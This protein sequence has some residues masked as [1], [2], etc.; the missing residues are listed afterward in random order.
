[1]A[2]PPEQASKLRAFNASLLD[3]DPEMADAESATTE[4]FEV[5]LPPEQTI[6]RESIVMRRRRPVLAIQKCAAV[7]EFEDAQDVP[8]WKS[9]LEGAA[10]A[11]G[12]VIPSVGRI[13]LAGHPDF[14]WVGTGWLVHP[15]YFV[16]NRHVAEVFARGK[17]D[18]FVMQSG[19]D[20]DIVASI[21]LLQEIGR[22]DTH[23]FKVKGISYIESRPGLD[24]AFFEVEQIAG[25]VAKPIILSASAPT[26]NPRV[27]TIGYP[28]FDSRIPEPDLMRRIYGDVFDKKRLAPGAIT[29]VDQDRVLHNCTTLGGNSGSVVVDL[30]SGDALG[31]HF[32]G[33][34]LRTNFAVRADRVKERLDALLAGS[35]GSGREAPRPPRRPAPAAITAAPTPSPDNE[36]RAHAASITIPLTVTVSIGG[37]ESMAIVSARPRT[38]PVSARQDDA[39]DID[40]PVEIEVPARP[41]D[42]EDR[43]GYV[44]SFL[45]NEFAVE[46]PKVVKGKSEILTWGNGKTVLPYEHFS[47]VMN[48]KRRQ[49]FFSA[50]NINGARSKSSKRAAWRFDPRIPK[51]MQIM[52]E[53]Y[54]S[55]PKFSR[56]HMTRREDPAW[57]DTAAEIQRG[58][59]DSMHVTNVT[60]QM[61][62]FNA[63]IWLGL[64]DYALQHARKDD[65]KISVFTGPYFTKNDPTMYGVRIP[66]KFWKV[67]AFVHDETGELCATGYEMS[68]EN[69][70]EPPEFV[71]GD[72]VSPQFNISTQ[73][74]V[75]MIEARTG[76]SFDVLAAFDP[77]SSEGVGVPT[78]PLLFP[79]QIRFI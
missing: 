15:R 17:G 79:E 33:S 38:P 46:L 66:V 14:S 48:A 22:D 20:G 11:L 74:P 35:L 27:A 29:D 59:D 55:T 26:K 4:A 42:Y 9:R 62:S 50:C 12:R 65:Q 68:Q 69:N 23:V 60:P 34:F 36:P 77:L 58:A 76:L 18:R 24:L 43:K 39:D 61:Q 44:A 75:A 25:T 5:N 51:E 1:M 54:G 56:G 73:V 37:A 31:L 7:L 19:P 52:K 72:F 45:G 67:I 8:L 70:L 53:C 32:S 49:C 63:P 78:G 6:E 71:F 47:V 28:A 3:D 16:T 64:E 21:D 10:S 40:D 2:T 30:K 57:G 13:E 41:E